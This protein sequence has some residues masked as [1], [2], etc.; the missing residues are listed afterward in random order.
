LIRIAKDSEKDL[1]HRLDQFYLYEFSPFIPDQYKV[2]K[3]G[4]F[5]DGDYLD[6]WEHPNKHPYLIFHHSEIAGFDK[7]RG[8]WLVESLISNPKSEG[9]WPKII[10]T[11][12]SGKFNKSVQEPRKTHHE[13]SFTNATV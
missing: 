9:F 12:A 13:Y 8:N 3:D 4:L 1:V 10:G 2:A 5:H 6:F 11:Y 7:H